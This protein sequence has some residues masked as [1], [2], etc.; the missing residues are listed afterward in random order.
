MS[1]SSDRTHGPFLAILFIAFVLVA[2]V[3]FGPQLENAASRTFSENHGGGFT[4]NGW[5]PFGA[6]IS[7]IEAFGRAVGR[8]MGR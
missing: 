1:D 6:A 7:A 4:I 3:F 5:D 8:L 2:I